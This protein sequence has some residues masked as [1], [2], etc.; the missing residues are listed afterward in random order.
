MGLKKG[1]YWVHIICCVYSRDEH[2][3][4]HRLDWNRRRFCWSWSGSGQYTS[5]QMLG[6]GPDLDWA[7]GTNGGNFVVK[8]LASLGLCIWKFC[9]TDVGLGLSFEKSGL[10]LDRKIRQSTHL[11]YLDE[12]L[13]IE[14]KIRCYIGEVF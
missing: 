12:L 2:S 3:T 5:L 4:G 1:K 9:W 11:C 13:C 10:H 8:R 14:L 7:H 6:S